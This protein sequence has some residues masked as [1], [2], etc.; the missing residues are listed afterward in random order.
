MSELIDLIRILGHSPMG[1]VLSFLWGT[2]W[3][4]FFNVCILRIPVQQSLTV[5]SSR[6]PSC[7]ELLQWYHNIPIL[8]YALLRGKC[9]YCSAQIS[10]QYPLVELVSGILFTWLFH[11]YGWDLRFLL[12]GTLCSLLLVI[13]VIDF[14]HQ[15]IPDELSLSGMVMGVLVTFLLKEVSWVQ[16]L[17]GI[18]LGGGAFLAVAFVY[19]R[20]AGRE[21]LGGGDVKLLAMIGAWLGYQSILPVIVIS[22]FLGALIGITLMLIKGRDFKMAIPFGPFLAFA[23]FCYLFWGI[24]IKRLLFPTMPY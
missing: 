7:L 8:S 16:S 4:S 2:I 12:Y 17:L 22:S 1:T 18:L 23:A 9:A 13:S 19:E 24:E 5:E 3:G 11:Q 14:Y 15:I 6:C 21:G 20:L 10:I